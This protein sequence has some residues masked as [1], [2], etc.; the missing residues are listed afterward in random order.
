MV[1]VIDEPT[2]TPLYDKLRPRYQSFVDQYTVR[3]MGPESAQAAGYKGTRRILGDRARALLSRPEIQKALD[4]VMALKRIELEDSKTAVIK[5]LQ[6]QSMV[7]MTDLADW[8]KTAKKW[9]MKSPDDILE[10]FLPVCSMVSVS[11]ERDC[12]F[13]QGA[14][15][16]A[17]KM[18]S[19]YMLW[20]KQQRDDNPAVQYSF[21]ELKPD[22]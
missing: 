6:L 8:D 14:Q 20:D 1:D 3:F 21:T 5:R 11:R 2:Q 7:S 12:L 4:E 22:G 10:E 18:L 17:R 16:S 15:D 13:N 19:A 9:V